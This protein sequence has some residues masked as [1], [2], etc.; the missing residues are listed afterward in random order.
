MN[1]DAAGN[2]IG[3]LP[4]FGP[5]WSPRLSVAYDLFGDAR[6]AL[7]FGFNKYVRDVGGRLPRRYSVAARATDTRDWFDCQLNV[8]GTACCGLNDYG[9]NGDDIAH[10]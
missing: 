10:H 5:D 4:K 6:T 1:F 8:G 9:S 2:T 3:G 7:K